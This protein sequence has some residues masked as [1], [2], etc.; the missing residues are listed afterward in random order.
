MLFGGCEATCR[1]CCSR[2]HLE[3][4]HFPH[5]TCPPAPLRLSARPWFD[6]IITS[7]LALLLPHHLP[8]AAVEIF[9]HK[10]S[11][12]ACMAAAWHPRAPFHLGAIVV[13][14]NPPTADRPER[15]TRLAVAF[16]TVVHA[17]R[18]SHRLPSSLS[19]RCPNVGVLALRRPDSRSLGVRR[20]RRSDLHH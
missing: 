5:P 2:H 15:P 6:L 12:L 20:G 8:P 3:T 7:T 10:H 9:S 19:C 14:Q 13:L 11:S 16:C 4:K 18:P 17:V 1:S